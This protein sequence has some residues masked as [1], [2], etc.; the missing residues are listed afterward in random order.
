MAYFILVY[1]LR[2][3]PSL[4]VCLPVSL[5]LSISLSLPPLSL[6]LAISSQSSLWGTLEDMRDWTFCI[7]IKK[8]WRMK[9]ITFI[10]MREKK[11]PTQIK[12][13]KTEPSQKKSSRRDEL[14]ECASTRRS[15]TSV[16][17]HNRLRMFS[18]GEQI[19]S[20]RHKRFWQTQEI[21]TDTRH[22]YRHKAFWQTQDIL[23]DTRH[24]ERHKT[25]WQTQ[26]KMV[27][28]WRVKKF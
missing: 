23:T 28:H 18:Q 3:N 7:S 5:S 25:F 26:E 13:F 14:M 17:K 20:D 22:S 10:W 24:S 19:D 12:H 8:C 21:L 16:M 2:L 4:S 1:P 9:I 6:S 15:I 27:V 11:D